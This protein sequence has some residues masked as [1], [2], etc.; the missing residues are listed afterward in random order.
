[1]RQSPTRQRHCVREP[2]TP[3]QPP[4]LDTHAFVTDDGIHC[5]HCGDY[6]FAFWHWTV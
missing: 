4:L 3:K 6:P 1:V 5:I 2:K